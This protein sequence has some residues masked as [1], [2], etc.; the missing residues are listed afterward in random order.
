MVKRLS[1][2]EGQLMGVL[3]RSWY[4]NGALKKKKSTDLFTFV[5]SNDARVADTSF[6][7]DC[8]D[9]FP[10]RVLKRY[11]VGQIPNNHDDYV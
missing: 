3:A 6:Q 7:D 9:S 11:F 5:I 1:Y 2:E 10:Y 4:T 8:K